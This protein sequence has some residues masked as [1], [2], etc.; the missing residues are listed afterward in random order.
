MSTEQVAHLGS[1]RLF[2]L[3]ATFTS[4]V[5]MLFNAQVTLHLTPLMVNNAFFESMS[6]KLTGR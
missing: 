1:G 6:V 4:L 5:S 2:G 3:S